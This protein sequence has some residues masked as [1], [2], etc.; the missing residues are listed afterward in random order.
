ML[1][2][3]ESIV[4]EMPL[5]VFCPCSNW[6]FLVG[7]ESSSCP[8]RTNAWPGQACVSQVLSASVVLVSSSS[9]QGFCRTQVLNFDDQIRLYFLLW[10]VFLV[11]LG[12][13]QQVLLGP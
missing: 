3:H 2:W 7:F 12:I 9:L 10:I 5:H 13:L 6:V 11:C 8:V 4:S 1:I